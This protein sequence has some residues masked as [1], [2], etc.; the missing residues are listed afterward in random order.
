MMRP[1]QPPR[2]SEACLLCRCRWTGTEWRWPKADT[3]YR[4][5]SPC[6]D[7]LG[8]D[9]RAVRDEAAR[10]SPVRIHNGSRT[11]APGFRSSSPAN[12]M[13][14]ALMDPRNSACVEPGDVPDIRGELH[15]WARLVRE[16]IPLPTPIEP[17]TL[18]S[19]TGTLLGHLTWV[20][21]QAWVD[22]FRTVIAGLL[23]AVRAGNGESEGRVR[24]GSCPDCSAVL[25]VRPSADLITCPCGAYWP[26]AQWQVLGRAMGRAA[27]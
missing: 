10:L 7:Q 2:P 26:R 15:S 22:E 23:L 20:I 16:E 8:V 3:G 14:I 27:S 11:H 12:D 21:K 19:E 18:Q 1:S 17:A 4:T 25:S 9:L 5:C 24:I 13:A 6:A